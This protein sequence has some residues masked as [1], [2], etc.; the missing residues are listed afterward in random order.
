M[1]AQDTM[2]VQQEAEQLINRLTAFLNDYENARLTAMI[3]VET[4]IE[5]GHLRLPEDRLYWKM[6]KKELENLKS[7]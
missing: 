7:E 5:S 1:T 6:V 3:T 4:F 2:T